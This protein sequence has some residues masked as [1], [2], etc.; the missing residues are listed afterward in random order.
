[1]CALTSRQVPCPEAHLSGARLC[2]LRRA[3]SLFPADW[4]TL[5]AQLSPWLALP[6]PPAPLASQGPSFLWAQEPCWTSPRDTAATAIT[7]GLGCANPLRGAGESPQR[8]RDTR[9]PGW[10]SQSV[11][12]TGSTGAA[13]MLQPPG[14]QRAARGRPGTTPAS[15]LHSH[16][17]TSNGEHREPWPSTVQSQAALS[18]AT[19]SRCQGLSCCAPPPRGPGGL[20]ETYR[21]SACCHELSPPILLNI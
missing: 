9:R 14:S 17:A 8:P 10:C 20:T 12:A 19:A 15:C 4:A 7:K 11:A 13:Q 18:P 16:Q 21:N 5:H 6:T 2:R 1:M 3:A